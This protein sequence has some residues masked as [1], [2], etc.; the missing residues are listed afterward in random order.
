MISIHLSNL[1]T[2]QKSLSLQ[3]LQLDVDAATIVF[4][5]IFTLKGSSVMA[6][7]SRSEIRFF[8]FVI[9]AD[10]KSYIFG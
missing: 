1:D 7:I 6:T 3:G 2:I 4:N 10:I 9:D 8:P 5:D